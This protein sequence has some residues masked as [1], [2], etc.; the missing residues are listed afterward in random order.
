MNE[1]IIPNPDL[2]EDDD[3]RDSLI[4][5]MTGKPYRVRRLKQPI[6]F[7]LERKESNDIRS[8][9]QTISL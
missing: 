9:Q 8:G 4:V 1:W 2:I 7:R 5:D 6:G 3:S